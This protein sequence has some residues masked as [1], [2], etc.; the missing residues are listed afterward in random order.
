MSV[1]RD[2]SGQ[3]SFPKIT[4]LHIF[5]VLILSIIIVIRQIAGMSLD[6]LM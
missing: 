1:G 2:A 4:L 6:M 3:L 5:S